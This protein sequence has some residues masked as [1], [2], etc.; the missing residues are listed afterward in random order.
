MQGSCRMRLLSIDCETK[1]PGRMRGASDSKATHAGLGFAHFECD[2]GHM[3]L[4]N[5][6]C[7][8]YFECDCR[9]RT[10]EPTYILHKGQ[11]SAR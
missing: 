8:D 6:T 5:H 9:G 1:S 10:H 7:R 3:V 11:T 2:E 4:T